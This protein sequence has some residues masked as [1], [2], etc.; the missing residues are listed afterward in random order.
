MS[1]FL[2]MKIYRA[3]E[4]FARLDEKYKEAQQ[5]LLQRELKLRRRREAPGRRTIEMQEVMN[6]NCI[7]HEEELSEESS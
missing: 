1:P 3:K 2:E 5:V 6:E 7:R 4:F